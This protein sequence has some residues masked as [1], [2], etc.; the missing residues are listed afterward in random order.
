MEQPP[1]FIAQGESGLVCKLQKSLYGLKQ[2]PR[3]W[4]GKFS[5]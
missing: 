4:F 3:A 2:S 5:K 1:E